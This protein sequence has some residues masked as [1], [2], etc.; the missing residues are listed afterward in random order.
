MTLKL[1]EC[2]RGWLGFD[3]RWRFVLWNFKRSLRFDNE[4][5]FMTLQIWVKGIYVFE[6]EQGSLNSS[7]ID[8]KQK[9]KNRGRIFSYRIRWDWMWKAQSSPEDVKITCI[10][11]KSLAFVSTGLGKSQCLQHGSGRG[12][13][14]MSSSPFESPGTCN[15]SVWLHY[16][17]HCWSGR[18]IRPYATT[19]R[20]FVF[21]PSLKQKV[22]NEHRVGLLMRQTS[23]LVQWR[24]LADMLLI[25]LIPSRSKIRSWFRELP[26]SS[27]SSRVL[28]RTPDN[29]RRFN[30]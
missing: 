7:C 9:S 3:Y 30:K 12:I 15:E 23:N 24:P 22:L 29:V 28:L 20:L 10:A 19:N 6:I 27:P 26:K 2:N 21:D 16:V 13:P 18:G 11:L 4:N 8:E 14:C 25:V 1:F 17:L 5:L